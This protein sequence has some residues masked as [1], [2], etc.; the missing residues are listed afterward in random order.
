[1]RQLLF[2]FTVLFSY[3]LDTYGQES[4]DLTKYQDTVF[5]KY[6]KDESGNTLKYGT[7]TVVF[8]T[9]TRRNILIGTTVLPYTSHQIGAIQYGLKF[10]RVTSSDCQQDVTEFA[11]EIQDKINS[12]LMTDSTL[13][14]DLN[15]YDNCGYDFLCDVSVDSTATLN[16]IYY[17]YGTWAFCQCCFGLTYHFTLKKEKDTP[18]IKSIMINGI[19]ETLKPI[20]KKK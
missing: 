14:I 2:I 6:N 16:L 10:K 8:K 12:I 18:E 7:D 11:G 4:N 1:M 13:T 5:I 9:D 19:R 3:T 15:I 17:G 20:K